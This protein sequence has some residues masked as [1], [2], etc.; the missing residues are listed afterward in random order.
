MLHSQE[1]KELPS[2]IEW[3]NAP[4][5]FVYGMFK[6]TKSKS[7]CDQDFIKFLIQVLTPY[8]QEAYLNL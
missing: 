5:N 2:R 3:D 1:C 7:K 6:F 4:I 8:S